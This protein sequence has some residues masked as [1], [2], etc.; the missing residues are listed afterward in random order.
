M[1]AHNLARNIGEVSSIGLAGHVV[2]RE[3][4]VVDCVR[5]YRFTV[6][7]GMRGEYGTFWG[8]DEYTLLQA[9]YR[10]LGIHST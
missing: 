3:V 10:R 8:K 4:S 7:P 2:R 9:V 1:N 6:N 5:F